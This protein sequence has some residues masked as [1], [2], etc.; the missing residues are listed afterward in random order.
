MALLIAHAAS[1]LMS[2][3]AVC[4]K[5]INGGMRPWLMTSERSRNQDA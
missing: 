5:W 1:F 2:K 4:S 3:S